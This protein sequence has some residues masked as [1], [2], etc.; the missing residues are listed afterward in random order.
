MSLNLGLSAKGLNTVI[1]SRHFLYTQ[2]TSNHA[3]GG[4]NV[5]GVAK[6]FKVHREG[7]GGPQFETFKH[8]GRRP[9]FLTDNHAAT[10][11]REA[12]ISLSW[13]AASNWKGKA[14]YKIRSERK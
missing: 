2:M 12:R 4:T 3:K 14:L 10:R 1:L 11:R 8:R 13:R 9:P 7:N 6:G 5:S